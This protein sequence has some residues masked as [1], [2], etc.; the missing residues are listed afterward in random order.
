M[1]GPT[2]K[3]LQVIK[4]SIAAPKM[5]NDSFLHGESDNA[6]RNATAEINA[7]NLAVTLDALFSQIREIMFGT[8]SGHR[9][10]DVPPASLSSLIDI[11]AERQAR[12]ETPLGDKNCQNLDYTVSTEFVPG[13]LEVFLAGLKLKP[14]VHF[15]EGGDSQSFSFVLGQK[16]PRLKHAPR[17][18][19]SISVNYTKSVSN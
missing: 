8:D 19:Q 11:L 15:V 2:D 12:D 18:H 14:G 3:A 17:P 5:P 10:S 16:V 1:A 9:W 6:V 4:E 13:T 7:A